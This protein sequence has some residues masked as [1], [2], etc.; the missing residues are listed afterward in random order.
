VYCRHNM[1]QPPSQGCILQHASA[2]LLAQRSSAWRVDRL[3][4][5]LLAQVSAA[6][7]ARHAAAAELEELKARA[8]ADQANMER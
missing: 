8:L 1:H 6:R 7:E 5:L 4:M 3:C 2:L